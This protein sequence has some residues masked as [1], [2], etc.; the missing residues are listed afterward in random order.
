MIVVQSD[1]LV[2]PCLQFCRCLDGLHL[3]AEESLIRSEPLQ[4][5]TRAQHILQIDIRCIDSSHL[6]ILEHS[7]FHVAQVL[8]RQHAEQF[9]SHQLVGRL[10]Q[11]L[12]NGAVVAAPIL[13]R[14]GGLISMTDTVLDSH[15]A[16]VLSTLLGRHQWQLSADGWW[17]D[18]QIRHVRQLPAVQLHLHLSVLA[19][20]Y[21]AGGHLAIFR[22][23]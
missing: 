4:F 13:Y 21:L 6:I 17:H 14:H 20:R 7:Q 22:Y 16:V 12:L 1:M 11:E 9:L 5:N 2:A 19:K 10:V 3:L 23:P 18:V 15:T 8:F